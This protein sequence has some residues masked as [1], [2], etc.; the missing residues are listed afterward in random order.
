MISTLTSITICYTKTDDVIIWPIR[1]G[2]FGLTFINDMQRGK[3][4]NFMF[5]L[6]EVLTFHTKQNASSIS[7]ETVMPGECHHTMSH[8]RVGIVVGSQSPA[9]IVN[10]ERASWS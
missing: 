9:P 10:Q 5:F 3:H 8:G 2:V 6:V 1:T 7:V 4:E